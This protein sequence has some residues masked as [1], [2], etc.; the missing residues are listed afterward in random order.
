[1]FLIIFLGECLVW[2][3]YSV[4]QAVK[5]ERIYSLFEQIYKSDFN[6]SGESHGFWECVYVESGSIC[7]SAD[8]RVH[9]LSAGEIIFHKPYELHKFF[10]TSNEG[11]KLFVFSLR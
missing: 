3:Y 5:I 1:M 10:I 9:N 2:K 6:F 4:K 7:V 11:A 8:E